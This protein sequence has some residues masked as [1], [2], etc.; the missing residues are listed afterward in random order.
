MSCPPT[1]T[2]VSSPLQMRLEVVRM[3]SGMAWPSAD[4]DTINHSPCNRARSFL[5]A[6]LSS[7]QA[8]E[9]AT[10][11]NPMSK[12]QRIVFMG[13]LHFFR[14]NSTEEFARSRIRVGH[15]PKTDRRGLRI[16]RF[17][18]KQLEVM[19][20]RPGRIAELLR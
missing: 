16:A 3:V 5:T 2:V 4:P 8:G 15:Q 19:G 13:K 18:L 7:A 12:A 14:F 1:V 9:T 11:A 20:S 17:K 6:S 10:A